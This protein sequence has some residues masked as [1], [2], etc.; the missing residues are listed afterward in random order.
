VNEALVL[1]RPDQVRIMGASTRRDARS[2]EDQTPVV[3]SGPGSS[4][5][6]STALVTRL[7]RTWRAVRRRGDVSAPG[8][9]RMIGA[10]AL[11]RPA[12]RR[13]DAD[14]TTHDHEGHCSRW[15]LN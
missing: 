15:R 9:D 2:V 6:S 10:P 4:S 5:Q 11:S 13:A 8:S 12:L 1:E 14:R 3:Y 7:L